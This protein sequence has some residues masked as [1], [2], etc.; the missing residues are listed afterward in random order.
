MA[1]ESCQE[2]RLSRTGS[3]A[4]GVCLEG[5]LFLPSL[6]CVG[7]YVIII[8]F[9]SKSTFWLVLKGLSFL[10]PPSQLPLT[11]ICILVRSGMVF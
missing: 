7:F 10:A 9:N 4:P 8:F 3:S 5:P 11:D 1:T 6:L 2:G